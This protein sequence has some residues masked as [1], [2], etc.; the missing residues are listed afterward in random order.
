MS[1]VNVGGSPLEH[2][3]DGLRTCVCGVAILTVGVEMVEQKTLPG[4]V[5][6]GRRRQATVLGNNGHAAHAFAGR[7]VDSSFQV[8]SFGRGVNKT[9]RGLGALVNT[10]RIPG[11]SL[12][13]VPDTVR[14]R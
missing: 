11:V 10:G 9:L 12:P 7:A 8:L 6:T 3:R 5:R 13:D 4:T 14:D 2:R 1:S